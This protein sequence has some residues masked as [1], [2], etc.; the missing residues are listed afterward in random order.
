MPRVRLKDP[1]LSHVLHHSAASSC[2]VLRLFFSL[3][4]PV[5][6]QLFVWLGIC[7]SPP[8]NLFFSIIHYQILPLLLIIT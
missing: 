5:Y 3:H 4:I 2:S 7:Q 8:E 1:L 6:L